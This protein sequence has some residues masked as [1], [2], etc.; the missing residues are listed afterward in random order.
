MSFAWNREL[1]ES[2]SEKNALAHL[3]KY[4]PGLTQITLSRTRKRTLQEANRESRRPKEKI[5]F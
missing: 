4:C 5:V 3:S 2:G 1:P